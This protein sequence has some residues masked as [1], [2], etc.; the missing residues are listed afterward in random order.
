MR[1]SLNDSNWNDDFL[2]LASRPDVTPEDLFDSLKSTILNLRNEFVP[3]G[4]AGKPVW[5]EKGDVPL[6]KEVREAIKKK[7]KAH[8][9]W[10]AG[11]KRCTNV[12]RQEYTR[13]RNKVNTMLRKAKR[14]V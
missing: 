2:G 10:M 3:R 8:R 14:R 12:Q 1:K 4:K 9:S 11:R 5:Q 13:A 7:E 6:E